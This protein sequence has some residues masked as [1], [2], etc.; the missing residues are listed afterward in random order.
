[1][2]LKLKF[3]QDFE[4]E[5]ISKKNCSWQGP[6]AIK[7]IP[8]QDFRNGREKEKCSIL[9]HAG[10]RSRRSENTKNYYSS[11]KWLGITILLHPCMS[12]S[13]WNCHYTNSADLQIVYVRIVSI[14]TTICHDGSICC[15]IHDWACSFPVDGVQHGTGLQHGTWLSSS[16]SISPWTWWRLQHFQWNESQCG[17]KVALRRAGI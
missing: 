7:N 9:L 2:I 4:A 5:V 1:M 12:I 11:L 10:P 17:T 14:I 3:G 15:Y 13:N 6:N 16:E 8:S